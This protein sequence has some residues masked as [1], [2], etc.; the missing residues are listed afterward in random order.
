MNTDEISRHMALAVE[1]AN[2]AAASLGEALGHFARA[3]NEVIGGYA[4]IVGPFLTKWQEDK[5]LREVAT[6]RQ[7]HLYQNGSPRV[8]KKWGNALR[9][10]K[11]IAEKRKGG[12]N[13]GKNQRG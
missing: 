12:K 3:I 11:R 10:K 6:P 9:R 2:R 13:H 5:E 7:W 8:S 1:A 4:Q